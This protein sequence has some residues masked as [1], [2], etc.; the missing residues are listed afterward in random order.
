MRTSDEIA[1]AKELESKRAVH[2]TSCRNAT[3]WTLGLVGRERSATSLDMKG[4]T[5]RT[6]LEAHRL[7]GLVQLCLD[8]AVCSIGVSKAH[9]E[10]LHVAPTLSGHYAGFASQLLR[11]LET[12]LHNVQS[13]PQSARVGN[14]KGVDNLGVIERK[15]LKGEQPAWHYT[16]W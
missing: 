14:Y 1:L 2:P 9:G 5:K 6:C 4:G 11:M 10:C 12:Q 3:R 7:V 15:G 8:L 16:S 13:L